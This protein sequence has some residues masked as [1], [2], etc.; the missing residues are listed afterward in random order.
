MPELPCEAQSK[1][2]EMSKPPVDVSEADAYHIVQQQNEKKDWRRYIWD[3][4]DK[5]PE[6]RH[7]IFKLDFALLTF[8]CLGTLPRITSLYFISVFELCS[9]QLTIVIGF[10]IK[11]LDQA[12][13]VNAFVSGM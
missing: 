11:F 3:S 13:L 12:N 7:F 1:F 4:F 2:W 8:G 5:S 6:E 9:M 10:F